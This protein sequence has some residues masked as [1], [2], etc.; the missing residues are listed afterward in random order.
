MFG[1]KRELDRTI[2]RSGAGGE[3]EAFMVCRCGQKIIASIFNK[4]DGRFRVVK[5]LKQTAT[6]EVELKN[7]IVG[8]KIRANQER[9]IKR[10]NNEMRGTYIKRLRYKLN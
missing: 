2:S 3:L 8:Q 7:M 1:I 5:Y 6:L 4:G 9:I 10:I